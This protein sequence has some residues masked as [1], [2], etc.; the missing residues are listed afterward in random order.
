MVTTG[1]RAS[2]SRTP[3]FMRRVTGTDGADTNAST[4]AC[5]TS[6]GTCGSRT[7]HDDASTRSGR[8]VPIG[9]STTSTTSMPAGRLSSSAACSRPRSTRSA[10]EISTY[11]ASLATPVG[12]APTQLI[13]GWGEKPAEYAIGTCARRSARSKARAMSRWL[14]KRSRPRL[15]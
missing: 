4:A 7:P 3:S 15:V 13:F 9:A 2:S 14:V 5:S 8:L 10:T 6:R 1:V 11:S 12:A